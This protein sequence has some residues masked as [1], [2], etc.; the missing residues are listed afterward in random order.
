MGLVREAGGCLWRQIQ[1]ILEQEIHSG[2]L[3]PGDRLATETELSSRFGVN[4]HTVRRALAGLRHKGLV[5]IEQGRGTFVQE[6]VLAYSL[7][8][9][10]R[11]SEIILRQ[12]R[13][14]SQRYLAS[15]T[16]EGDA[17]ICRHL[18][19][20]PS[21]PLLR[22]DL[23]TEADGQPLGLCSNYFPA[24]RFAGLDATYRD[25]G[26]IT[27]ALAR[28]GVSDYVRR[29]TRIAARL[30]TAEECRHLRQPRSRPVLVVE[31]LNVD[32]GG[33]PVEYG[34]GRWR[35]ERVQFVVE[36]EPEAHG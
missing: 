21:T 30:P 19:L 1:S 10:V 20:A 14:P 33:L 5:R 8:R 18:L 17:H 31:G 12:R 7:G 27:A 11:F 9:R 29:T 23:L 4:R 6:D 24:A 3:G 15:A 25:T 13:T 34:L 22:L 36:Q 28:H 2:V 32:G 16:V 35:S 26:S